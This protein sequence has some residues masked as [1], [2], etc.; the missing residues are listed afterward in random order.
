MDTITLPPLDERQRYSL[1]ESK[2]YLRLSKA[3]L[4]EKIKDGEIKTILDG[5]RRYVPGAE[6]IRLSRAA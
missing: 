3:R 1:D 4:F 2:D 6:L 5:K